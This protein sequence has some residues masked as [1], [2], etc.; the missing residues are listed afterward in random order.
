MLRNVNI[1]I[2]FVVP[3]SRPDIS[4][5]KNDTEHKGGRYNSAG[6]KETPK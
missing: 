6:C 5:D 1:R 3:W 4:V 2:G